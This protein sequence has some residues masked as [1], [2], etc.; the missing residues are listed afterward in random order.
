MQLWD[1]R[2]GDWCGWRPRNRSAP[3]RGLEREDGL[4]VVTVVRREGQGSLL[5]LWDCRTSDWRDQLCY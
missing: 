1:Y 2:T 3:R 5:Q 4:N